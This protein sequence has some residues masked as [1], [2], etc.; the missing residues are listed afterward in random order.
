[1]AEGMEGVVVAAVVARAMA[2]RSQRLCHRNQ[3]DTA[4]LGIPDRCNR[5]CLLFDIRLR[6]SL[7]VAVV[8]VMVVA[9]VVVAAAA[10]ETP[11]SLIVIRIYARNCR[12]NIYCQDD[13]KISRC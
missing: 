11:C 6:H 1:M 10:A 2:R 12:S 7:V 5:G 9:V 13:T 4:L 3:L 8:M